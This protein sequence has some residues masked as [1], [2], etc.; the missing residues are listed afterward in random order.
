MSP[1]DSATARALVGIAIST[2][3][4]I[5]DLP[6]PIV[7]VTSMDVTRHLQYRGAVTAMADKKSIGIDISLG[8]LRHLYESEGATHTMEFIYAFL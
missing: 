4:A 1:S 3:S 2:T 6:T 5:E 7:G 8:K